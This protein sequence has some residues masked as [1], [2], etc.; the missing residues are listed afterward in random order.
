MKKFLLVI[1]TVFWV[2]I[3]SVGLVFYMRA[4]AKYDTMEVAFYG[5]PDEV[6]QTLVAWIDERNIDWKP[7]ILDPTI[8]LDE[9]IKSPVSQNLLFT[10][11][12]KNMDTIS[13]YVRTAKTDNLMVMPIPVRVSVITGGRLTATP[14]LANH[15]QMSYNSDTLRRYGATMPT[16]IIELEA[17]S[18]TVLSQQRTGAFTTP[19]LCAGANDDDLIMFFSAMLETLHGYENFEIA[20]LVLEQSVQDLKRNEEVSSETFDA[21]FSLP[22]VYNT[23]Q[24]INT[25]EQR[26]F[27]SPSWLSVSREDVVNAMENKSPTFVFTPFTL[28]NNLSQSAKNTYATWYMPSGNNRETRYLIAPTVVVMEFSYVK[29]PLQ[30]ARRAGLKNE[31]AS[32]LITELV[33]GLSQAELS[34][35]SGL[36]PLNST[37]LAP[38]MPTAETR[39]I[40]ALSDGLIPDIASAS[41]NEVEQR[42]EFARILRSVLVQGVNQ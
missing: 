1:K 17:I 21:F 37:A 29:S 9:Q 41:F 16:N 15:F 33:S 31:L 30:S 23:L 34:A 13:P 39:Q 18:Q 38:D 8:P 32:S 12:G 25:W 26:R 5:L 20:Q 6:V 19:I 24:Y 3:V 42:A 27:L 4:G 36:V 2:G 7:V 14:I 10:Y 22:S 40:F 11:D 28:Y 35:E